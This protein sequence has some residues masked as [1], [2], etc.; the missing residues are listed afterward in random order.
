MKTQKLDTPYLAL[1]NIRDR[2]ATTVRKL[3][4][5][6]PIL[7][8]ARNGMVIPIDREV[9]WR[10][11]FTGTPIKGA[12]PKGIPA[13]KKPPKR[14]VIDLPEGKVPFVLSFGHRARTRSLHLDLERRRCLRRSR[15]RPLQAGL[16]G[17]AC[18]GNRVQPR[19]RQEA[20]QQVRPDGQ[21][22]QRGGDL[23]RTPQALRRSAGLPRYLCLVGFPDAIPQAI[24]PRNDTDMTSDLP[25][26]NADDDLFSEIAVGRIIG[27][28]ATF[29]T[30]H[31]SRVVTYDSLLDPHGA[32]RPAR[33]AG[34]TR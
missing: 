17:H 21:L 6:A 12:L 23:P 33:P 3:S 16:C 31:A 32:A 8:S 22:R 28:S 5:A 15:R 25:Y 34:R 26:G 27:E 19:L 13:G 2:S 24:M 29:A 4:L 20:R 10:V 18:W 14:G 30:L 1:V 7:A 11:P 9:R